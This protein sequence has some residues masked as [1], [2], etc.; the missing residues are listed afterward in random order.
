MV[1]EA[2]RATVFGMSSPTI[3]LNTVKTMSTLMLATD[4]P[5]ADR[6]WPSGRSTPPAP[7]RCAACPYAPSTRLVSVMPIWLAAI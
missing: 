1:V 4:R 6:Y 2:C 7:A 5:T 3:T